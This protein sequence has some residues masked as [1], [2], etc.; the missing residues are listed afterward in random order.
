LQAAHE[1]DPE[2]GYRLPADEA[3]QA[4]FPMADRTAWRLCSQSGIISVIQRRRRSSGKKPG[5]PVHD[6][7]VQRDFTAEAPNQVWLSDIT[8]HWTAEGKLYVCAVKDLFSNR[9][10]GYSISD[11]MKSRIV[12]DAISAAVARRGDVAGC[13]VHSDRG[14]QYGSRKVRRLLGY[15]D[16][17]GSM[18]RVGA[19]GD[20]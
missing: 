5:P 2:F 10:V 4:G 1:E 18:G 17:V 14:S 19:A 15:H 12:V 8:E 16:L 6:D 11:R 13:I 9:I 7:H 3:R 20:N